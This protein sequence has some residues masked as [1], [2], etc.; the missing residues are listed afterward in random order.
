[1]ENQTEI[2]VEKSAIGNEVEVIEGGYDSNQTKPRNTRHSHGGG[3]HSHGYSSGGGH[4]YGGHGGG[5]DH[6]HFGGYGGGYHS[7]H[8]GGSGG[9]GYNNYGYGNGYYGY[10]NTYY[11]A[12]TGLVNMCL[13][14][15][16][17]CSITNYRAR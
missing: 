11:G 9:S 17:G 4:S 6:H 16:Y 13:T 7:Q 5:L 12:N 10:G 14:W 3:G 1:M 8:Y 15:P 2:I